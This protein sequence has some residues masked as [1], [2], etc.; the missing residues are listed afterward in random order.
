MAETSGESVRAG[1][2]RLAE[3][4]R[5]ELAAAGL[6]VV[7]PGL[8]LELSVGADVRVD[9]WNHRFHGEEPEVIVSWRVSPQLR[10]N[11][12]EDARQG[13]G[14]TPAIRQSGEVQ[15]AMAAAVIAILSAAG[16]TA[17]DHD[18][19]MSPFGVQVLAGPGPGPRPG[20]AFP[21]EGLTPPGG[22]ETG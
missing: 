5:D 21:D 3:R 13:R 17:R 20:W 15:I 4:V 19:D 22:C 11:A 1:S 18:N 6:P 16:F 9:M 10:S 8:S 12:M 2:E 7:A 14:M